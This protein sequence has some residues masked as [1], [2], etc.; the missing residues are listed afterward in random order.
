MVVLATLRS[1]PDP[2]SQ[3]TSTACASRSAFA[4]RPTV[5]S[6]VTAVKTVAPGFD[7]YRHALWLVPTDGGEARQLTIGAKND[8]HARFSPDGR[9]VAFLSDRRTV[10]EEEPERSS[11]KE[12]ED[13][14][15]VYLLP[16]DGGEARRLTDLPRGVS[17]FEWSPDGSRLVVVSTSHAATF[18][19]DRKVRGLAKSSEP[20]SP[21]DSDYR[22]VDRLDYMLNG[23]GFTYD[24]VGHLWL[25]DVVD[26][27]GH[28]PDRRPD[29]R[30]RPG[31][32]AGWHADRLLGGPAS[33]SRPHVPL[34]PLHD[35]RRDRARSRP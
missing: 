24:Q 26:R 29:R 21:P 13:T 11:I 23:E 27:R 19:E 1:C 6:V 35:R 22:F 15:Q 28:P 30:A 12:R 14:L 2:P 4:C 25:V 8:W 10:V 9:T 18:K 33:R 7:G 31:L 17:D 20:G 3:T 16:V 34:G 5:D 32:V